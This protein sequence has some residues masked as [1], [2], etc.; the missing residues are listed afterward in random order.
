MASIHVSSGTYVCAWWLYKGCS[1]GVESSA[2]LLALYRLP[3]DSTATAGA[4]CLRVV[5]NRKL[6]AYE[7]SNVV[8]RGALEKREGD[9]IDENW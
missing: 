2:D 6:R 3:T 7:L 8:N 4:L 9:R 1:P 5:F